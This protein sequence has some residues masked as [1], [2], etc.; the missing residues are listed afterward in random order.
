MDFT[1][2]ETTQGGTW[3]ISGCADYWAKAE[4][5]WHV[6][7]TQNHHD[8]ITAIGWRSRKPN[9]STTARCWSWSS[10]QT[11]ARCADRD[12]QRQRPGVQGHRI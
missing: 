12:R 2:L 6:S 8:A 7:M 4:L 11:P 1:E 3:R 5:G 10:T 9:D